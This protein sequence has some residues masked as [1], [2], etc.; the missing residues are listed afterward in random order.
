[1]ELE[2]P[3]D[4]LEIVGSKHRTELAGR[5]PLPQ[6]RVGRPGQQVAVG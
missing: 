3:A 4:G 2:V 5:H 6:E 1:M